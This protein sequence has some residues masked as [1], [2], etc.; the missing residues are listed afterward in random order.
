MSVV[1]INNMV[2]TKIKTSIISLTIIIKFVIS[3]DNINQADWNVTNTDATNIIINI[4]ILLFSYYSENN[5]NNTTGNGM[6]I[7]M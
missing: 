4:A 3:S 7:I 1:E 2:I 5:S 6:Y